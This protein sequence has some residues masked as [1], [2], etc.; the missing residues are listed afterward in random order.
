MDN[1][2]ISIFESFVRKAEEK[3]QEKKKMRKK[4]LHIGDLDAN[5]TIRGL[6][7]QEISDCYDFSDDSIENDKYMI[8]MASK[9]LQEASKELMNGKA[10]DDNYK[11]C[12]MFSISDRGEI[13]TQILKL[14]GVYDK[15]S[16]TEVDEVEETKN[17]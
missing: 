11:I 17:S 8:Y 2:N 10:I 13:A 14:S 5:I 6:S 1:Q 3:I 7:N 9:D 12:D 16:V 15:T 4:V